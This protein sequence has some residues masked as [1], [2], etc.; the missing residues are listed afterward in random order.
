M[1]VRRAKRPVRRRQW[2]SPRAQPGA[3]WKRVNRGLSGGLSEGY[4][5]VE[6]AGELLAPRAVVEGVDARGKVA[7]VPV[8]ADFGPD[9]DIGVGLVVYSQRHFVV[10]ARVARWP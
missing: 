9:A 3:K 10:V 4:D 8:V 6:T 5:H 1:R 2:P 7:A